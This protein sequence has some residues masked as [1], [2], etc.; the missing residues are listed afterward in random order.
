MELTSRINRIQVSPTA[1]VINAAE[2]LKAK[3]VD[4]ADF[5]PGEPDFPT[6]DH[7]KK[8]AI[9]AIEEN[10]TKYTPTGGIMPLRE[11]ITAWHSRELGS[12]YNA[13]ECVVNVGGK[14]SIFNTMCVLVQNGD[15]VVLCAPYWVS[16][17]DIVKYAGGTPVIVQTRQEDGF[18]AKA[19]AIEKAI[20]PKTKM[21]IVN[22]PSNPTGGVVDGEEYECI[23]AVCKKHNVCLMGDECY[24]H[25]VY[26]PHKPYSIASAKDSKERVIIIGSMSKT[27][28]M[29]GWRVGYTLGPEPL[30]QAIVKIQSQS[31]SNPTSIAQY[32]ALEA[33]RGSMDSVPVML[34]EYAK[35]RKRIVEGLREIPGVTCEWPGG[36][37]YAFPNVSALLNEKNALA[38]S[39]TDLAKQ[40]LDH[41]HVA[42]VPGEAFGAPGFLRLSYATSIERIDEG[43]RRL[44][45]FFARAEAAF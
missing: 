5:G 19:A 2:Q 43:L 11:A 32:A 36:A 38:T 12:S 16:Y 23:L 42:L 15:E 33:M 9:R 35:R 14:H 24:S 40:L 25:F 22:S 8:A 1:V 44:N 31:T 3:G 21:V 39:C 10:R 45:K 6:P 20:T 7:I 41:A 27:F 37:F 4:I 13:K 30:I 17:P 28:A 18:S 29:T 34:A 26:E